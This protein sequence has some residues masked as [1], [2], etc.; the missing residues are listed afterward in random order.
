MSKPDLSCEW[1]F[2][3][4]WCWRKGKLLSVLC[5]SALCVV[6]V[7]RR[8][9]PD[10]N[11]EECSFGTREQSQQWEGEA[12]KE[13]QLWRAGERVYRQNW[14]LELNPGPYVN[15]LLPSSKSWERSQVEGCVSCGGEPLGGACMLLEPGQSLL[16]AL[17]LLEPYISRKFWNCP[18]AE[19]QEGSVIR[20]WE[21]GA[22]H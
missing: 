11:T 15:T 14:I 1:F 5:L 10:W 12:Q 17:P 16:L 18:K 3:E 22:G 8:P 13:I 21:M 9:Q 4:L 7:R 19:S 20:S 6:A 2:P